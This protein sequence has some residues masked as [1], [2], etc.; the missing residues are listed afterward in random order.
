MKSQIT[1]KNTVGVLNTLALLLPLVALVRLCQSTPSICCMP[2]PTAQVWIWSLGWT[3]CSGQLTTRGTAATLAH[4]CST[5]KPSGM[6]C[7]GSWETVWIHT[8]YSTVLIWCYFQT[9]FVIQ[10]LLWSL[11][12][13][14]CC[15]VFFF[16]IISTNPFPSEPNSYEK[17][18]GLRLDGHQLGEDFTVLRKI[19]SE[20]RFYRRARLY[21][22][23]V[24][25]LRDHRKDI[26]RGSGVTLGTHMLTKN[27]ASNKNYTLTLKISIPFPWRGWECSELNW[28]LFL[29]CNWMTCELSPHSMSHTWRECPFCLLCIQSNNSAH[30][31]PII[32]QATRP[33]ILPCVLW[34]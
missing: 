5:V 3:L 12:L 6:T 26:L 33:N 29:C 18:A 13:A 22:P 1:Q 24:G 16:L 21:G 15:W 27:L 20:S 28:I 11:N 7:P 14:F 19:L 30:S 2:S 31:V 10:T 9:H 32:V 25:Q 4:C 8:F 34:L 23:D 17:K